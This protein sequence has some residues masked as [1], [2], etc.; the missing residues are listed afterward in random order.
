MRTFETLLTIIFSTLF[1]ASFAIE[2]V[3]VTE[4]TFKL[5]GEETFYYGFA[6]GDQIIFDFTEKDGK[7]IKEIEI[8][9][10]PNNTKFQDF[11][12]STI[13]NKKINVIRKGLYAF[14]FKNPAIAGRICKLKIQRVPADESTVS[15]DTGW[16]YENVNDTTFIPYSEDSLIGYKEEKYTETVRELLETKKNAIEL[17][18]TNLEIRSA[19]LIIH[20]NPKVALSLDLPF[21]KSPLSEKKVVSWAF[22]FCQQD[23]AE[24]FWVKNKEKIVKASNTLGSFSGNPLYGYAAGL[25]A[26]L[27][28]PDQNNVKNKLVEYFVMTPKEADL[29]VKGQPSKYLHKGSGS[30]GYA[31][32]TNK[33]LTENGKLCLSF[34]N[35]NPSSRIY[36]TVKAVA[37]IEENIYKNVT[38]EKV[39][40]IPQYTTLQKKKIVVQSKQEMKMNGL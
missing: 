38:S 9:E 30:A 7:S 3:E 20:D 34:F 10:L 35:P 4:K 25:V 13:N 39:K 6:A 33:D 19:G 2:P 18:N 5:N 26:E 22:W 1:Y 17:L 27:A 8:I 11:K 16:H 12:T 29:F 21:D 14:R 31:R 36:I 40:Q 23:K 28:I 37:I 15:F 32:F 24:S